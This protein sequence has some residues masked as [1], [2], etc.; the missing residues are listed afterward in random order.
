MKKNRINMIPRAVDELFWNER[1][2]IIGGC[3]DILVEDR[4][5]VIMLDPLGAE[6]L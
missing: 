4:D 3:N 2:Q 5:V 1:G 6:G